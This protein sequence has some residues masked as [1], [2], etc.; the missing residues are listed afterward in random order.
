MTGLWNRLFGLESKRLRALS[1]V[2]DGPMRRF[3]ETPLPDIH[4]DYR[5]ADYVAIDLE[6]TG[7]DPKRNQIVSF[8]WV[9]M[10]AE[11]VALESHAHHVVNV[12]GDLPPESVVIH[13]VTDDMAQS[14]EPLEEILPLALEALAGRVMIAHYANIEIHFISAICEKLYGAPLVMPVV[15]TLFIEQRRLHNSSLTTGVGALRL[16][17]CRER[18]NLPRYR[19]HNAMIDALACGELF[20]AQMA[21]KQGLKPHDIPLKSLLR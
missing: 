14:A 8:G 19:A 20:L 18:Y 12:V 16:A 21:H 5:Q 6:T 17:A 15:D 2:S 13:G 3:L 4:A 10:N 11:R 7:L 1:R 9:Q